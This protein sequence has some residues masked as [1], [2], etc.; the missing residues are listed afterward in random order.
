[1]TSPHPGHV[2]VVKADITALECDAWL[3]PTD[4]RFHVTA[5]FGRPVGKPEGGLVA[6]YRWHSAELAKIFAPPGDG[7]PLIVLG[8]VGRSPATNPEQVSALVKA[9]LPVIDAFVELAIEHCAE[10]QGRLLR[11]ALPLL[12]TGEGGL[13]GAKGD[14][15]RPLLAHLTELAR[16]RGIDLILC[17]DNALTWSAVQSARTDDEW[18]LTSSEER[19]AAS[20]AAEA[21]AGRLVFF[22]GAGVSRDAGLPD[23][24]G[25][26]NALHRGD[27]S[28]EEKPTLNNLDPRDHAMLIELAIGGRAQLLARLAQEVGSYERFGLT[29]SLLA[30]IGAEQAVTTN[31]DNLYER[32]CTRPGDDLDDDLAV[33][34]Y[35]RVA[36]NRP[37]L[38]KLHGSLDQLDRED[39]IVLTR[40]DYMSLARDRSALFGIVQALL[41]TKHLLFVGYSL[42]DEDFHQLVDEIRIAI[43]PSNGKDVLGTVVTTAK[44]PLARLW[45]DLLRVE[46]IGATTELPNRHL[47]V[48][49]DR[50]AHLATPHDAHLLDESFA[51][52]LDSEEGRIASSLKAVQRVVDDVLKKRPDHITA[53]A[54]SRALKQFGSPQPTSGLTRESESHDGR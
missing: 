14:V 48:F 45:D 32:A 24:N 12:G 31:Y 21:R 52:L 33:L 18:R 29:H 15:I 37:W 38:L 23:W 49:L 35:G 46:Q 26:L 4:D 30:S 3:C 28:E 36:E 42:S 11:I 2:F 40:P 8:R 27:I 6:G 19:L 1:M 5:G 53:Q 13:R 39:H 43:G 41:V 47:Q 20:L 51:G 16:N 25:L 10:P 7:R 34:P 9:L 54:V 50:V 22:I 17:T 44:W